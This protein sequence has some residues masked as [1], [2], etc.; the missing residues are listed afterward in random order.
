MNKSSLMATI[1][2]YRPDLVPDPGN[3][4]PIPEE[5]PEKLQKKLTHNPGKELLKYNNALKWSI[6]LYCL[7]YLFIR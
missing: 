4:Q 5:M 7:Y 2:K 1:N 6:C 3:G